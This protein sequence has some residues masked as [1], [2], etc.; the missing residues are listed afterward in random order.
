M[1]CTDFC[2]IAQIVTLS[3][4][5]AAELGAIQQPTM[6]LLMNSVWDRCTSV[7]TIGA[8]WVGVLTCLSSASSPAQTEESSGAQVKDSVRYFLDEVVTTADRMENNVASSTASVSVVRGQELRSLPVTTFSAL[9]RCVPGFSVVDMDGTGRNPIINA[10]GFYGG[11][12]AE[13]SV[14]LIDGKQIN[15]LENGLVSWNLAPLKTIESIEIARGTSSPLY[16]DAALGSVVNIITRSSDQPGIRINIHGGS[17]G[18]VMGSVQ[19]R[20]VFGKNSYQVNASTDRT[21]GFRDHS[22]WSG[23]NVGGDLSLQLHDGSTLRLSTMNQWVNGEDPGPL[24][25]MEVVAQRKESALYYQADMKDEIRN[26]VYADYTERLSDQSILTAGVS[27][28]RKDGTTSRTF[29]NP[30]AILDPAT[31]SVVGIYDTTLYGD[32]KEREAMTH[33]LGL[34]LQYSHTTEIG[35]MRH[36]LVIGVDEAYGRLASTYY[37][38]QTGF[39]DSYNGARFERGSIV[40]DGKNQRWSHAVYMNNELRIANPLTLSFG[41]RYD[42]I[43]DRVEYALPDTSFS[44][45]HH[46]FSP[47][48]GFNFQYAQNPD[49]AGHFYVSFNQSFKAPTLDQLSDQRPIDVAFFVP[50]GPS[51][52][53]FIPQRLEPISNSSLKPQK[54]TSYETGVYQRFPYLPGSFGELSLSIYQTD[55]IDEIDFDI[56]TFRYQNI[57][58][59]RHRGVESGLRLHWLA[60]LMTFFNYTWTSVKFRSGIYAGN[61]LKSVPRNI[62]AIGMTYEHA[63]GLHASVAWD[64]IADIVM[65]DENMVQLPDYN[66]GSVRLAYT[67]APLSLFVDVENLLGKEFSTTGYVLLGTKYVFPAAGRVIRGGISIEL[68]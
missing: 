54:G 24:T 15:D 30:A 60:N 34:S 20:G 7:M 26:Q 48:I 58:E 68:R 19:Q 31:F 12:E 8:C 5:P 63:S 16:G 53:M 36:R 64:F 17:L 32:T 47:K 37:N 44:I 41:A 65:D 2:F 27:Y 67:A 29:T 40:T 52:Y 21:N 14:V 25:E 4:D 39:E 23:T 18:S 50:T 57:V 55:M 66:R 56:A 33:K 1:V 9:F 61:Y 42:D 49:Y 45:R 13:Y 11:G 43:N 46:A 51:A 35:G 3:I 6:D 38:V 59:S 22:T 62:A 10:R 28:Q